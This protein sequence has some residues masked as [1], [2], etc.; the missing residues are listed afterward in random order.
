MIFDLIFRS[1]DSSFPWTLQRL[2][3][4]RKTGCV[5]DSFRE[6]KIKKKIIISDKGETSENDDFVT[7]ESK[8]AR[9]RGTVTPHQWGGAFGGF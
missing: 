2:A 4:H 5:S 7:S 8:K 9:V 3:Q 6:T 1:V